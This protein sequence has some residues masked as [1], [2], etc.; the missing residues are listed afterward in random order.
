M[1]QDQIFLLLLLGLLVIM[2][3]YGH[4]S[5]ALRMPPIVVDVKKRQADAEINCSEC[6]GPMYSLGLN[7]YQVPMALHE[8]NRARLVQSMLEKSD[9]SNSRG[10]I[11]LEGGKQTTRYDTD[12]EP[13]FRQ[14]SFFH[15]TFG[16][17]EADVYGAISLPS[18]ESTLFVPVYGL[19]YEIVCGS[20]PSFD[21]IRSKYGVDNVLPIDQLADYIAS[22]LGGSADGTDDDDDDDTQLHLLSGLNTDSGN[23]CMAAHYDGIEKYSKRRN[24]DVLFPSIVEARV[25]KTNAEIE[26]MRYTNW[27]SSMAHVEVMKSCQVKM[28]EYQ[29]E[30]LFQHYTYTHGGCR[31]MS[32][33]CI[34]AC[35]PSP[36]ILHYGH[37]GRP[38]DRQLLDGDIA[39]LDMGAEY[40]C[41][42][43]DITCSYPVN[44]KFSDDQLLI[45]NAVLSAQIAVITTLKPGVSYLDMHRLAERTILKSLKE[46]GLVVGE[47][48]D[49]ID[50]DLGAIFMP[51]GLGH[52]IGLD[53][54][55][56]GGYTEKITR[57]R[58]ERPGL[59]K[60]R[61]AR[62]LEAGMVLT[63]EPGCYF[64]DVLLDMALLNPKQSKHICAERVNEF[65]GS[66]GVRCKFYYI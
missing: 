28:M 29:L 19:D 39:L 55:D 41:Y 4:K 8:L 16:V 6:K 15:W 30:S 59:K 20:S 52:L 60:L 43:S 23:Y 32:Y 12:F 3:D 35:G 45:Y 9:G 2:S 24:T 57:P 51:H 63:V 5:S 18:G 38:N 46:G 50:A 66:G 21:N 26:L 53:A 11:L 25:F 64:I 54:H 56:V 34:C 61:T 10:V 1:S 36:S 42:A 22:Q 31:H 37:A 62:T 13:V 7:T 49:M 33:T 48:D 47:I 58:S 40:H 17:P 44:G 27:V 65:R 14:E